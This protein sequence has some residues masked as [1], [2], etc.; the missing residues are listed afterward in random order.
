M[1]TERSLEQI[2]KNLLSLLPEPE[3]CRVLRYE[4]AEDFEGGYASLNL[5]VRTTTGVIKLLFSNV[6][7]NGDPITPLRDAIGLYIIDTSFLGW[8]KKQK[9][10]VGDWD[11]GPPIFW[12]EKVE[13]L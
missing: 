6:S 8:D 10:E 5:S 11:G 9:I 2:K 7:L 3:T 1:E 12:S 4:Y 13:K